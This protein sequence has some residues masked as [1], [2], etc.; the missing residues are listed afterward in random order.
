M[1]SFSGLSL[2][3]FPSLLV[4]TRSKSPTSPVSHICG[5]SNSQKWSTNFEKS[6]LHLD[7]LSSVGYEQKIEDIKHLLQSIPE[8][9]PAESLALV[10]SVQ[11]LGVNSHF[12]EEI[13]TILQQFYKTTSDHIYGFYTLHDVSLLFRLLRQNGYCI[14]ADVFNNFKGKDGKFRGRLRQDT[15]GLMELYEAAQLGF[16]GEYVLDEAAN[17]SSKI[18]QECIAADH[19]DPNWS[20]MIK[21]KLRHPYHKT[22]T[23]FAEKDFFQE[24]QWKKTLRE[25]AIMDLHKRRSVYQ[26]E[27]RQI[28]AWWNELS[29]SDNLKLARNQPIKWYT[30]SMAILMDDINMS[31]QR[32]ELTKSISFIYLIDDIFDLYGTQDELTIFTEAINK[33]D[34]A[35][36]DTLPDYMKMCYRALLDTTHEIAHKIHERHGYNP[37]DFLKKP[38]AKLCDAYLLEA[39]WFASGNLPTADLYLRNGKVSSGVHVVLVHLFFLFGLGGGAIHLKDASKLISSVATILRLWNDLGSAKDENQ[40][41]KGRSYIECYK[42]DNEGLSIVEAREH[43]LDMIENEWKIFNEE[44][45]CVNQSLTLSFKRASLNLVRIIPMMYSYNDNQQLPELEEYVKFMLFT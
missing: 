36:I 45:F 2:S 17:F 27:L 14:S 24:F 19:M 41:G 1:A 13:E 35:A 43:V 37:I 10:D 29:L 22:I 28:S 38:W 20:K 5:A 34:Y 42:K 16:E 6:P 8:N 33:W 26:A 39:K 31:A 30:W 32:V 7:K 3:F 12:H 4:N 23:R 9:D 25:L 18:L 21:N 11:R 44:C 40:H 15:R